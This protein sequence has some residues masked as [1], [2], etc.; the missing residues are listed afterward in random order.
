[1]TGIYQI[2]HAVADGMPAI[3][4]LIDEAAA[5]L[6]HDKNTNQWARP[7]PDER[8]RDARVAQGIKDGLTWIVED[9]GAFAGTITCRE[10]G[11]DRLWTHAELSDPAVYVSR[12]I[13]RRA[14]AGM[15]LGSTLIDWAGQRGQLAWGANW[16]RIDVWTTNAAVH[17]Y[18]KGKG[19]MHIRTGDFEHEWDYPSAAL[20]QKP[21]A[22]IDAAAAARFTETDSG[23]AKW[24]E[25]RR[26]L[27]L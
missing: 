26:R 27:R 23:L 18:Y 12:L 15:G 6:Q 20:F 1:M 11:S 21:T 25:F 4:G 22:D 19:F 9:R 10:R 2:R 13:V 14:Q 24:P 5:W 3:L 17:H 16:I 8:A 7:W